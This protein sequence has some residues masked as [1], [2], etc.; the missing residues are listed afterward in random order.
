MM[1]ILWLFRIILHHF[2]NFYKK[3]FI[4]TIFVAIHCLSIY[5]LKLTFNILEI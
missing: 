5:S 1:L 2:Y 4:S 3:F